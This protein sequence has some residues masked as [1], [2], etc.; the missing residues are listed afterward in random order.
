MSELITITSKDN[1]AI[2]QINNPPVNAL[3]PGVPE[4]IAA[5]IER[6][7]RDP[8]I[9]AVVLMGAG[10]TFVA[11]ADINEL[12]QAAWGE[13]PV[14]LKLHGLLQRIE[15]C[16]KPVVMAIHGT[17]LGGGL[18][19]AMSGHFRVA[20]RDALVGQPEV[21]LGIIP[22][23]EGTQRLPRLAGVE[24]A[25]EM[26]VSGKPVKASDAL[27]AGILDAIVEG[28]LTTS[29]AAFARQVAMQGGPYRKTR[30][31][32]EKVGTAAQNAPLFAAGRELA[33]KTR[34]NVMAPLKVVDAIEA[35]ATLPFEEGWKRE[36][37]IFLECLRSEQC[38]ALIHAFFAERAVAKIPDIPKETPT[39][40]INTVAIIGAGTM[41][42]GIA[43]ACVNAGIPVLLK[44]TRQEALDKGMAAIR[45]N[46]DASVKRGRFSSEQVEQRIKMIRPQLDYA[47]FD[48][49]DIVVEAVFENIRL[50]FSHQYFDAGH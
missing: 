12:E 41:G 4:G 47:G 13:R 25:I 49:V 33:R 19:L 3:S 26:C 43:M 27:A 22:G 2:I 8:E 17:A 24:K 5:A 32:N 6:V 31:R 36:Q 29:A 14:D 15:D 28:D 38:K 23:A 7:E 16:T 40:T 20:V 45:R 11:G 44:D 46:Y 30:E 35:A 48:S 37:E 21:N 42:G 9:R 34:R 18:E 1:V 10:R 50:H 39:A